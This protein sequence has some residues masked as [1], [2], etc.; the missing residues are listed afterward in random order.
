MKRM[1]YF[2]AIL[3]IAITST[4]CIRPK[5]EGNY[6][7]A[8]VSRNLSDFSEIVSEGS[9]D[10]YYSY[11]SINRVSVEAEE[12]IIPYIETSV[13]GNSLVIKTSNFKRLETHFPIK[14][15][16]GSPNITNVV[17]SGSGSI[18]I[19]SLKTQNLTLLLKGS[20]N[21]D[22]DAYSQF[23]KASITGSG[24]IYLSG[25]TSSGECNISGSGEINA[26][27]FIQDTCFASI[28][29]SGSMNLQVIDYLNA[30][31]SGSGEIYYIGNPVVNTHIT[32]SGRIIHE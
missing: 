10:V 8:S 28:S 22:A 9:C 11:D 17:L 15:Y 27:N 6:H 24:D 18:T 31:I 7:V 32:G 20:G 2:S 26:Y 30:N 5:I 25:H 1:I 4:S 19:D 12:N 29:G 13:H 16:I 14:V 23:I 3:Y 21:I